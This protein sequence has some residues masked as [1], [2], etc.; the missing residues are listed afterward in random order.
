MGYCISQHDSKFTIKVEKQAEALAA[1]LKLADQHE[2][3][4]WVYA[5]EFKNATTLSEVLDAWRWEATVDDDGNITDVQ[6]SDEKMGDE[7]EH[8]FDIIAPY[9]EP[10]SFIELGGE[11]GASWRWVFD[12]KTCEWV[13]PKW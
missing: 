13:E 6:F 5:D 3:F 11:D 4:H 12:G 8:L 7:K 9:V 10:G 2:R 1:M